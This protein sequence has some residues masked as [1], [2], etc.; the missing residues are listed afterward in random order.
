R[1]GLAGADFPLLWPAATNPIL[2]I[3]RS[4]ARATHVR[5]PVAPIPDAPL[6][7]PAFGRAT[8]VWVDAPSGLG[9]GSFVT[10]DL[11]GRIVECRQVGGG[12]AIN[13]DGSIVHLKSENV[14]RIDAEHPD[15]MLLTGRA[16]ATM[17][18][19][20]NTVRGVVDVIQSR[21][22]YRVAATVTIDGK[23]Y[24]EKAW[25]LDL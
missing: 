16:E 18:Y 11:S 15:E 19:G 17:D 6:P 20:G 23:S 8:G 25:D 13:A 2:Q 1:F 22:H 10:R 14:S 7:G 21:D 4:P 9:R 12:P 3:E 24:F 5:L